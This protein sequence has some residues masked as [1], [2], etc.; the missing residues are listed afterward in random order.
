[1]LFSFSLFADL[2]NII[3]DSILKMDAIIDDETM[4]KIVVEAAL[5]G[6]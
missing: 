6:T 5:T 3:R 2:T 4:T 1:M